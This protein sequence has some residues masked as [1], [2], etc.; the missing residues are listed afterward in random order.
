M[1]SP[2]AHA[3][4]NWLADHYHI[5]VCDVTDHHIWIVIDKLAIGSIIVNLEHDHID[6]RNN[7]SW[8]KLHYEDPNLYSRLA[9]I[10]IPISH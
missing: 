6:V 3:T 5:A 1:K 8:V 2:I 4:H 10:I 9:E 7:S